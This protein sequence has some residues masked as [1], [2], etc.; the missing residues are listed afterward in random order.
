MSGV[1]KQEPRPQEQ[2]ETSQVTFDRTFAK[3]SSTQRS[4]DIHFISEVQLGQRVALI[5]IVEQQKGH[6][7]VVG[8][9][10]V[11]GSG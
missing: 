8:G 7:F 10:A 3:H 2:I 9:P 11:A 5:G 1:Q 6:S 4:D